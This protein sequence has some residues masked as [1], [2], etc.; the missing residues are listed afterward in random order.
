MHSSRTGSGDTPE[1]EL[2]MALP[3]VAIARTLHH[4]PTYKASCRV[5]GAGAALPSSRGACDV[6]WDDRLGGSG[7]RRRK[8]S[9]MLV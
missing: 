7:S 4:A 1:F 3:V 9:H 2:L 6:E 8:K 5:S